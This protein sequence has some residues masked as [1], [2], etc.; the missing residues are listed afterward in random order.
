MGQDRDDLT[1]EIYDSPSLRRSLL[2][3][4]AVVPLLLLVLRIPPATVKSDDTEED[5]DQYA[6]SDWLDIAISPLSSTESVASGARSLSQP[7]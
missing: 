6:M 3:P 1:Q 4:R 7:R 5:C 2:H